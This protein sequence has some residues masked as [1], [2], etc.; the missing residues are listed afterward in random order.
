MVILTAMGS[1]LF[2]W[3]FLFCNVPGYLSETVWPRDSDDVNIELRQRLSPGAKVYL[4]RSNGFESATDRWIPW[5]NPS[6]DVVVEVAT[7][8]DVGQ[9]VSRGE[10]QALQL[11][12][13]ARRWLIECQ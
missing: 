11:I 5:E 1:G 9:T 8:E 4:P 12:V 6:F 10:P 7:E 3:L 13:W 2:A